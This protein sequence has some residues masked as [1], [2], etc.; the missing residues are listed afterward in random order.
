MSAR[1]KA[2]AMALSLAL[3]CERTCLPSLRHVQGKEFAAIGGWNERGVW[4][5]AVE[6]PN[7]E[8]RAEVAAWV[9]AHR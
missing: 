2:E 1:E 6:T 8:D 5:F 9:E 4:H 7:A 3:A